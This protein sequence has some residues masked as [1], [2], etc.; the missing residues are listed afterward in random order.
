MRAALGGDPRRPLGGRGRERLRRRRRRRGVPRAASRSPSAATALE[1][2]FSGTSRQ[3]RT[4]INATALDVKTT[5]GVALKYLFDPR[6]AFTS[7][8][9]RNIDIVLPGGHGDQRAAARR[10]GVRLLRAEPGDAL[11]AA[12]R[13]R[14]RRSARRRSAGDRGGT[15]IHNAFGVRP[16]GTPWV[17][18]AQC[19]GEIGPFGANAPRRRRHA[20]ALLPGQRDRDSRSRRSRPTCPSSMLRHETVAGQ[21][22]RRAATA[23]A[24]RWCATRCGSRPP[25]TT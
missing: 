3:A 9:Y 13:V 14:R 4:C 5:V 24:R 19:G 6:G 11:R 21:R 16:D 22:R 8:L 15:D 23:A 20:D 10:R 18:A 7:G 2:D 1:V 25:S 17:S 12:A